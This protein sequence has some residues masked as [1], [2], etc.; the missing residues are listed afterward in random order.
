MAFH[1]SLTDLLNRREFERRLSDLVENSRSVGSTHAVFYL[2]L[3]QFKIVNDTC[4]H[5]AG[6]EL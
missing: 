3:D 1:D 5:I 6:D 4:G 2:D